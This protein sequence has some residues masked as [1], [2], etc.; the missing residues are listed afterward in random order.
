MG[1]FE[2][3]IGLPHASTHTKE[4]LEARLSPLLILLPERAQ[5]GIRIGAPLVWSIHIAVLAKRIERKIEH[6]NIY[7]RLAREGQISPHDTLLDKRDELSSSFTVKF[8]RT[9]NPLNLEQRSLRTD[10][11][12]Q[13]TCRRNTI[14]VGTRM[15]VRKTVCVQEEHFLF[16]R[17]D[18]QGAAAGAIVLPPE[19]RGL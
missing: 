17:H 4:D 11:W 19:G 16:F 14:S 8:T 2:H 7:P 10:I 18:L 13:P 5:K 3:F 12:I 9:D 1:S 6:Q 15:L